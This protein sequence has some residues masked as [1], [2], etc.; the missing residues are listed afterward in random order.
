[1]SGCRIQNSDPFDILR[2]TLRNSKGEKRRRVS[3]RESLAALGMLNVATPTHVGG[4]ICMLTRQQK[5]KMVSEFHDALEP[6][7]TALFVDYQGV[8]TKGMRTLRTKLRE[9][10]GVLKVVRKTLFKRALA[11]VGI[12]DVPPEVL[13]GQVGIV[14][15]FS[16]PVGAAKALHSFQKEMQTN[17]AGEVAFAIR[18][19]LLSGAVL[20]AKEAQALALLP[21]RYELLSK[22]VGSLASPMQGLVS[23]FSGPQRG[24]LYVLDAKI[25]VEN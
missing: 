19:G 7:K 4:H 3:F 20:S 24:L 18:G 22:L 14:Y 17:V 2:V 5:E 21:S 6:A 10:G 25:K 16:D 12:P 11:D 23:V 8:H 15:G 1:M 9:H 13:E